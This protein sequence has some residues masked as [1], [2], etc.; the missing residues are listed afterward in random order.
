[1]MAPWPSVNQA[2][3]LLKQE[4][5]QRQVHSSSGQSP[6]ALMVNMPAK[7]PVSQSPYIPNK[8][9]DRNTLP[10]QECDYCHIKGHTKDRC[11]KLVGYPLDDPFHPN[12]KGKKKSFAANRFSKSANVVQM[13]TPQGNSDASA[14]LTS[15]V[16]ELQT[17][18]TTLMQSLNKGSQINTSTSNS[19]A[20][21]GISAP[22]HFSLA[23]HIAGTIFS[24]SSHFSS[25]TWIIDTGAV[26]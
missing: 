15:K 17:Q 19:S 16:E 22:P 5:R 24:L 6:L 26:R 11:Y 12:N 25:D 21:T 14:H 13:T 3:M 10:V 23:I 18:L 7:S 8:F 4:E 9:S 1:M 2:F 20:H